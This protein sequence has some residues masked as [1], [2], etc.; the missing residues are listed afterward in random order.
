V[1]ALTACGAYADHVCVPEAE[2]VQV[3]EK[4]D[5]LGRLD[6]RQG[7]SP[8]ENELRSGGPA[9]VHAGGL[10]H[11]ILHNKRDACGHEASR[12]LHT[13]VSASTRFPASFVRAGTSDV[14]W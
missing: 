9:G 11:L 12:M 6:S 1:A 4:R 13:P 8:P 10:P 2:A 7:D 3:P 5:R 14:R